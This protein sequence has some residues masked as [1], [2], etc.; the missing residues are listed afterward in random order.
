VHCFSNNARSQY[1]K[2]LGSTYEVSS[3]VASSQGSE[4]DLDSLLDK[5]LGPFT[6]SEKLSLSGALKVTEISTG[7]EYQTVG[8]ENGISVFDIE[9][10][11][12]LRGLKVCI[13]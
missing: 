6:K 12:S 2:T 13:Y 4:R 9:D 1:T 5:V 8:G 3:P 11:K 7:L 10:T